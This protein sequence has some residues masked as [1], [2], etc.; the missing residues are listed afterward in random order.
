MTTYFLIWQFF[1]DRLCCC[2]L[3]R[4]TP[5]RFTLKTSKSGTF[6]YCERLLHAC[7]R[8][9]KQI[10][11][12]IWSIALRAPPSFCWVLSY[13]VRRLFGRLLSSWAIEI[14]YEIAW[15]FGSPTLPLDV[16]VGSIAIATHTQLGIYLLT[17]S[18]ASHTADTLTIHPLLQYSYDSI[19]TIYTYYHG[20]ATRAVDGGKWRLAFVLRITDK[21]KLEYVGIMALG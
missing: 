8:L 12:H 1:A 3:Q 16:C 10:A 20:V 2:T 13:P 9:S 5:S 18:T 15:V 14:N 6:Y 11:S 19:Y 7:M 4:I 17:V 21:I